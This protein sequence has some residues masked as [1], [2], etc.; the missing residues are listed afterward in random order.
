MSD[1]IE[2]ESLGIDLDVFAQDFVN[3]LT[4][5]EKIHRLRV[6]L[7]VVPD[8]NWDQFLAVGAPYRGD[9]TTVDVR[10]GMAF[11][12]KQP[13]TK[14]PDLMLTFFAQIAQ[15]MRDSDVIVVL[16]ELTLT[17]PQGSNPRERFNSVFNNLIVL[18][19][20]AL[21]IHGFQNLNPL[22]DGPAFA[23]SDYFTPARYIVDASTF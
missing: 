4:D 14:I 20:K 3:F 6:N 10:V 21:F 5:R 23:D 7:V 17:H 18:C 16:N 15:A 11:A 1:N 2:V 12:I 8:D 22:I 19:E 9:P 13:V